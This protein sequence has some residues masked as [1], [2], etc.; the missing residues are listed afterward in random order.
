M[1]QHN[2][3]TVLV[4][5]ASFLTFMILKIENIKNTYV[6]RNFQNAIVRS[7]SKSFNYMCF[8]CG[9]NKYEQL[10]VNIKRQATTEIIKYNTLRNV[11]VEIWTTEALMLLWCSYYLLNEDSECEFCIW[12]KIVRSERDLLSCFMPC[13]I[14]FYFSK[15]QVVQRPG[16]LNKWCGI[17]SQTELFYNED[18]CL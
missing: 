8:W 18:G 11:S 7:C 2:V 13:Q 3:I 6:W 17:F 12:K 16:E 15:G 1:I 5:A 14:T 10:H 4:C 9:R